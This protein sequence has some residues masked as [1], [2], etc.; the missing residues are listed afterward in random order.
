MVNVMTPD[1]GRADIDAIIKQV[2]KGDPA[3]NTNVGFIVRQECG[4]SL[5]ADKQKALDA[6]CKRYRR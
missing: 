2:E 1:A 4:P 3:D 5:F 6:A